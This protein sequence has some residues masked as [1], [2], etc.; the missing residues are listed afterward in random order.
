MSDFETLLSDASQ[1]P[2]EARI[3]LIDELWE[4]IPEDAAP[5][6]SEEWRTEINR[7]SA[8]YDAGLVQPVPWEQVRYDALRRLQPSAPSSDT[9]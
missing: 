1:L 5:P 2:L 7:R 6:L 4:T 3:H 8:E 9:T